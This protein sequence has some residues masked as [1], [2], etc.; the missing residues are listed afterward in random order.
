MNFRVALL[1]IDMQVDFFERQPALSDQRT[2]LV[3]GINNLTRICRD[4]SQPVFWIRQEFKDDLSDAF[5][6]MRRRGIKVTIAD[7]EGAKI[8]P[9]LNITDNDHV[10]VKK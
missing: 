7:T 10:I 9:E 5:L 4:F 2:R 3:K 8:L 6:D 1:V